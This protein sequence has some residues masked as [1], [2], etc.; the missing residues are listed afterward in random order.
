MRR[1]RGPRATDGG[2]PAALR[3]LRPTAPLPRLLAEA[4]LDPRLARRAPPGA[5]SCRRLKRSFHRQLPLQGKAHQS[6]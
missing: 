6:V 3:P 1:P 5:L 2:T 4:E